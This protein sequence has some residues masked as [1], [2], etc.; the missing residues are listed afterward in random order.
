MYFVCHARKDYHH[1]HAKV[2]FTK[3]LFHEFHL[4]LVVVDWM[5]DES[6]ENPI[7]QRNWLG[8]KFWKERNNVE[9]SHSCVN[10]ERE[11]ES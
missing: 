10:L 4:L 5:D 1:T 6:R 2:P 11:E 3:R 8:W 7:M 9:K